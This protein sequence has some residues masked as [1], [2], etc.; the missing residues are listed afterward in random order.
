M[1]AKMVAHVSSRSL[2]KQFSKKE[3]TKV[4]QLITKIRA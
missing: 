1:Y 3:S 4:V 2:A